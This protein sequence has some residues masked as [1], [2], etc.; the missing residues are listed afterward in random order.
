MQPTFNFFTILNLLGAAQ[1][2]LLAL[3][4]VSIKRGPRIANLLLAAFSAT[5]SILIAWTVLISNGYG[6]FFPHLLRINQPLDFAAGPLLYLYVRALVSKEPRLKKRDL[7]HFIPFGLCI[8]YLLPYYF[9]S[10]EDKLRINNSILDVQWYQMRT[11]LVIPQA[12]LYLVLAGFLI[13]RYLR[14][15]KKSAAE[16]ATLF[17][18]K[19]F[20]GSFVALWVVAV[21]RYL[22]DVR[23][24]QYM[25]FTNMILPFGATIIIYVMAYLGL[26]RPETLI[27]IESF[28]AAGEPGSVPAKK[29]EKSTLTQE[30]AEFYLKK[31]LA[32]MET[33]KPYM[34]NDLTLPKLAAKLLIPTHHLS[35]I[36]NERLNQNFFDFVNAHRIEEAKLQLI[37]PAKKHY[38]LVAIA[39][40]VGF[41]SKSAFNS[42]FK[43]QTSVTPSEY[44]K[45]NNSN[46]HT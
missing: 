35:Q 8:L 38:S 3:A 31:L 10:G 41:N 17:Q 32:V 46:G 23:Y 28:S 22:W 43:K 29:Y 12:M 44:R 1:A 13:A 18:V 14:E 25:R 33:D 37:D 16:S 34:D 39:E 15:N 42:A 45:L 36:I 19:F 6:Y 30:R 7:L 9:Q 20:L 24:P 40:G 26:R 11:S 21:L 4:L 27:G 2:L 5:V